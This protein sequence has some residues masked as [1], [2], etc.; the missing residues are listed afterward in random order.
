M[1][2]VAA[3]NGAVLSIRPTEN[4]FYDISGRLF[5]TQD[6]NSVWMGSGVK[7]TRQLLAGTGYGDGAAL[8][9]RE[10]HADRASPSDG[11]H[12]AIQADLA[13]RERGV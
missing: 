1:V 7:T 6:A 5:C 10:W 3:G 13:G 11:I 9:V 2:S 4:F 8:V 12:V